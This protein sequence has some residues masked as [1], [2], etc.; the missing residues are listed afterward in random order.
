MNEK[1]NEKIQ[2]SLESGLFVGSIYLDE[3]KRLRQRKITLLQSI[4]STSAFFL[5]FYSFL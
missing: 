2:K 5:C 3:K 1:K 4:I